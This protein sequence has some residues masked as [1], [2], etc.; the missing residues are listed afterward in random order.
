[1]TVYVDNMY[2]YAMG[3]FNRG[4]R[5]YKMSHM[6]AESTEELITFVLS[7]GLNPK[8]IQLAGTYKEHFDI[9]MTKRT[10]AL[11]LGAVACS[12]SEMG[13][14]IRQRRET[15]SLGNLEEIRNERTLSR[16][17]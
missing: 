9:T 7:I 4:G 5:V 16:V 2:L 15:G 6:V 3:E 1:M 12:M 10:L 17:Q 14:L 13:Y 8:W 11:S